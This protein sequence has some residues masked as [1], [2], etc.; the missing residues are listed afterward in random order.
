MRA[1]DG[2][3]M[4][5][6]WERCRNRTEPERALALLELAAPEQSVDALAELPLAERNAMLLEVRAITFG[7]RMEGFAVCPECGAQ[8]EFA[9]NTSEL[10][11]GLSAQP[12]EAAE[13]LSELA[14]RPANTSDLLACLDA[15]SV[16]QARDILLART[17]GL[18]DVD[19]TKA[20]QARPETWLKSWIS[21][22]DALNASA[23]IRV[24]LQCASCTGRALLD[25]DIATFLALE[26]ALAA[27][28]LIAEIH[29]LAAS[30]GWS[31]QAILAMTASRR[32]AYLEML[33]A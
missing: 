28:R 7:R 24:E 12:P 30:Y 4:L 32:A 26:I 33:N 23:E 10:V 19:S 2:E 3:L 31:E 9:V 1:L 27:R 11:K 25:L 29:A 13:G 17:L 14:M 5:T 15:Q 20:Q 21:R 6:A 22:F 16:E 8:L 18:D